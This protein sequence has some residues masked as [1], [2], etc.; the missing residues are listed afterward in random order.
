MQKYT[1]P[2]FIPQV[3]IPTPEELERK[4][5]NELA[6]LLSQVHR[7][8]RDLR[9]YLK[10]ADDAT[11]KIAAAMGGRN[12]AEKWKGIAHRTYMAHKTHKTAVQVWRLVLDLLTFTRTLRAE[13]RMWRS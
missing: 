1:L 10:D 6:D 4:S 2:A 3:K 8:K 7:T 13:M 12:E 11:M 5:L 9:N